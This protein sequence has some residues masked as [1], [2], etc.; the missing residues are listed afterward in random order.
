VV[1]RFGKVSFGA[2]L[3][4]AMV[5]WKSAYWKMNSFSFEPPT[6]QLWFRLI[7]FSAFA[8]SP[9]LSYVL[10]TAALYGCELLFRP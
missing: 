5:F 4:D 1:T 7:E 10:V 6:T 2:E 8:L 3:R 9:Q